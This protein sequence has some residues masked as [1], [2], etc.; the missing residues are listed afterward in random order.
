[1]VLLSRA[2]ERT[3]VSVL[4]LWEQ[5]QNKVRDALG[6][7]LLAEVSSNLGRVISMGGLLIVDNDDPPERFDHEDDNGPVQDF[8]SAGRH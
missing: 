5:A 8:G 2:G 3:I 4:P 6:D 1:V 7:E